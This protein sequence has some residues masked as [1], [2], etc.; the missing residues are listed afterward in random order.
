M[1]RFP[2][3]VVIRYIGTGGNNCP[4]CGSPDIS[5]QGPV[6]EAGGMNDRIKCDMCFK[7]WYEIYKLTDIEMIGEE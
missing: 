3:N 1:K 4:Y 7:E 6:Y 5:S 2:T